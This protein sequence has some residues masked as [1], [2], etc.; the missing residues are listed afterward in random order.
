MERR[1][2]RVCQTVGRYYA[3]NVFAETRGGKLL[4]RTEQRRETQDGIF[5]HGGELRG[6]SVAS[7]RAN[8]GFSEQRSIEIRRGVISGRA[9]QRRVET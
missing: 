9:T 6:G 7:E 2:K 3:G 1:S 5:Q 8:T 4:V